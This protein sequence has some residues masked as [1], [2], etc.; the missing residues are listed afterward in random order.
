MRIKFPMLLMSSRDFGRWAHVSR[1]RFLRHPARSAGASR[2]GFRSSSEVL[3]D[4]GHANFAAVYPRQLASAIGKAGRREHQEELVQRQALHR[5]LDQQLGS[6]VGYVLQCASA[7]P[8]SVDRHHARW[9]CPLERNSPCPSLVR[10]SHRAPSRSGS[11]GTS[12]GISRRED[13][14]EE[15]AIE[16]SRPCSFAWYK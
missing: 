12:D 8:R 10:C 7:L 15:L 4:E 13:T 1:G 5:A 3:S 16:Q 6:A 9:N 2:L 11:E 14:S